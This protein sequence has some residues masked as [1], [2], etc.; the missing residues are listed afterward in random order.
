M[1]SERNP[2][3]AADEQDDIVEKAPSHPVTTVLLIVGAIALS[4]SIGLQATELGQYRNKAVREQL[5]DYKTKPVDYME[6]QTLDPTAPAEGGS[7]APRGAG[8][9]GAGQ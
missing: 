9:E 7:P 1:A 6:N 3:A 4:I 2:A 5:N 8:G